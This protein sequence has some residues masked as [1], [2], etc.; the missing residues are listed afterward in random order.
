[1]IETTVADLMSQVLGGNMVS[2]RAGHSLVVTGFSM[3]DSALSGGL[4]IGDLA[5]VGGLPGSGKTIA[6]L[7]WA[8]NMA[9]AG[10]HVLFLCYE[11]DVATLFGRLLA[12]EVGDLGTKLD[13]ADSVAVAQALSYTLNGGGDPDSDL[14]KHPVIRAA[15]AQIEAYAGRLILSQAPNY[16]DLESIERKVERGYYDVVI[17]DYVQKVPSLDG[18]V[19][20]D[21]YTNTV[22]GL[23]NIALDAECLVVGVSAVES[24]AM[25]SRRL[26]LDGLRGA[27]VLAH[28]AD[29]VITLNNKISVVS[30]SHLAFD[31]TLHDE[32]SRHVV[33][34]IEKNRR[35]PAPLTVEFE[36]D[37]ARFRF[38]P[39]GR[40]VA[41]KLID[42]IIVLE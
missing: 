32:F 13:P 16:C 33:F 5:V 19:G 28:E 27:H 22:E 36:K 35:G 29:V 24:A 10:N 12:L 30:K 39:K 4:H 37:F 3:L 23:K 14:L 20:V 11:H 18:L 6:T 8:R 15:M 17:V 9:V 21:R 38:E 34:T 41:E 25:E 31:S 40:F 42:D 7:Q 26:K 2:A 1:V